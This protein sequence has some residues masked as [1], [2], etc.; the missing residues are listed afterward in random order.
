MQDYLLANDIIIYAE[1]TEE[2]PKKLINKFNKN[3]GYKAN[4]YK[5]TVF[6]YASNEQL[7]RFKIYTSTP[8]K[9]RK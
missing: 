5:S 3:P 4:T 7:E 9:N 6:L 8:S 2:S 1:S